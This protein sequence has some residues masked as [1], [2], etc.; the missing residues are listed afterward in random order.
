MAS[1]PGSGLKEGDDGVVLLA[2]EAGDATEV[3][4]NGLYST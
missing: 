3:F 2:G 4:V 1:G